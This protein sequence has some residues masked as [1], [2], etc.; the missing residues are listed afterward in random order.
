MPALTPHASTDPEPTRTTATDAG[1]PTAA[2]AAGANLAIIA[3]A[4]QLAD[5]AASGQASTG[6]CLPT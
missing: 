4:Q 3:L 5:L 6:C 1:K 2:G